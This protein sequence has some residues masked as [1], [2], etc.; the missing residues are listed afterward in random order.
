VSR[1]VSAAP[2]LQGWPVGFYLS[3]CPLIERKMEQPRD[4]ARRT[5]NLFRRRKVT[6]F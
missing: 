2:A 1:L 6:D 3:S 4:L 5:V